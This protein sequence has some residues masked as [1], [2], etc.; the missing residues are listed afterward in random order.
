[1]TAARRPRL[2]LVQPDAPAS[3]DPRPSDT[4]LFEL[5][6]KL[7]EE[8]PDMTPSDFDL[9]R[10]TLRS[11]QSVADVG[12]NIVRCI[13]KG[14]VALRREGKPRTLIAVLA[15]AIGFKME[16]ERAEREVTP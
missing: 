5:L 7:R 14:A 10:E 4:L 9:A 8:F 3:T 16:M 11:S 2:R 13:F 1:M 6:P 12:E 15:R